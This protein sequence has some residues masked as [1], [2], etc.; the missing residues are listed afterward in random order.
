[1]TDLFLRSSGPADA[2]VIV[3]LHG[4]GVGGWMWR[5][6]IGR[7]PEYRCLAPDMPEQG[8]S[9]HVRPF[10]I[11]GT[12]DLIAGLIREQA[13]GG[14]AHVVGL[15]AGAQVTVALLSRAP[16]VVERAVISSALVRPLPGTGWMGRWVY[17]WSYYLGMAGPLKRWD[18]WI[19]LNMKYAAG[20]PE[21]C[22]ADFKADFQR[23]SADGL[24]NLLY[25]SMAFRIPP[26]LEHSTAPALV[27]VGEKEYKQMRA[28]G[29]DLVKALPRAVGRV[30]SQ[31]P[32]S[33]L[34]Q[35]HNWAVTAPELFAQTVR[36]WVEDEELPGFL[37]ELA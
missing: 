8:H 15:S 33:K 14:K 35:E 2:P 28:S 16:Q 5:E 37:K 17:K 19:K 12:A 29:K 10:S 32:L 24:A 34:A 26:G 23:T 31:G 30:H 20:I 4:G 25:S 6:V 9:Q 36:A 21:G 11:E 1:M 27:V 18:W 13:P 7:L 3:F 22:F